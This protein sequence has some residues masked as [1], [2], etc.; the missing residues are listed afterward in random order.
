MEKGN[1][2]SVNV[3]VFIV[4]KNQEAFSSSISFNGLVLLPDTICV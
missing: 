4:F 1:V 3:D 2:F